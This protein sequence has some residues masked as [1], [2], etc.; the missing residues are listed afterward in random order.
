MRTRMSG[1]VGAGRAILPA[2][3]L[4][5]M[6]VAPPKLLDDICHTPPRRLPIVSRVTVGVGI[7]HR[8]RAVDRLT[9]ALAQPNPRRPFQ[10]ITQILGQE[11]RSCLL[12]GVIVGEPAPESVVPQPG[13][14]MGIRLLLGPS[15]KFTHDPGKCAGIGPP[16]WPPLHIFCAR[17]FHTRYAANVKAVYPP[18][19]G[20]GV[21]GSCRGR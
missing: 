11:E 2:T 6:V 19:P 5:A 17:P 14:E 1:G 16:L 21:A 12:T 20:V 10:A 7:V 13:F 4:A 15:T 9:N 3:R 18:C 8:P